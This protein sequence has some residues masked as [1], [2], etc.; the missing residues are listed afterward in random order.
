MTMSA[1][2]N[3]RCF[4]SRLSGTRSVSLGLLALVGGLGVWFAFALALS[5]VTR[6]AHPRV[7]ARII[8]TD[9]K[10][11]AARANEIFLS[12]PNRPPQNGRTMALTA[13]Q[14][15]A[16][17]PKALLVLGYYSESYGDLNKAGVYIK[18]ADKLSPRDPA[19]QL[20]L[21]EW[22]ARKGD[23]VQ[24]LVHY[25]KALRTTPELKAV[26]F[27]QL[28]TALED[29]Q[30][31]VALRRY[32]REDNGWGSSFL[33]YANANSDNLPA[34]VR[35]VAGSGGLK[36]PE[37]V[38]DQVFKLLA[39]LVSDKHFEEARRF[40]LQV[41]G[42][43]AS[44]LADAGFGSLDLEGRSGPFGWQI[45]DY[46]NAG[47]N[48]SSE[49]DDEEPSLSVF[50]NPSTTLAVATKLLY[51]KPGAHEFSAALSTF[52]FGDRGFLRWQ[53]RCPS[54]SSVQPFWVLDTTSIGTQNSISVPQNCPVQ[55]LELIVSGGQASTGTEATV[56]DVEITASY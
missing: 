19:T 43:T 55:L 7:A 30:I 32:V 1:K 6:L 15:Q 13:L 46:P 31:R 9:G 45:L 36:D 3:G 47:G 37:A 49:A 38:R 29:P 54:N 14:H 10:A 23:I 2:R 22:Y 28:L 53:M 20:W 27:P 56:R 50:A 39:R 25:D 12:N 42:M 52:D 4:H 40:Y 17:N 5:G 8:P 26:L 18:Q 34:L 51:L 24:T 16:I 33:A 11:L 35:L 48:F 41:P 21:I 44:S